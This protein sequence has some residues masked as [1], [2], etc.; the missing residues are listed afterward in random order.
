VKLFVRQGGAIRSR[1]V[2]RST[3][4]QRC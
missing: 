2:R 4:R 1:S 3:V